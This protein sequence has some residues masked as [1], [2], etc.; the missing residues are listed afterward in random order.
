MEW[1]HEV[2]VHPGTVRMERTISPHFTWRNMWHNIEEYVATCNVCQKFKKHRLRYGELPPSEPETTPWNTVAV[3]LVGPYTVRVHDAGSKSDSPRKTQLLCLTM[4][5]LATRWFEIARVHTKDAEEIALTFD[6][7][8]FSR[9]PRPTRCLHDNGRKFL[10]SEFQELLQ[11]YGV[12]SVATS[13]KNPQTNAVLERTHQVMGNMLRT[14]ELRR[15]TPDQLSDPYLMDGVLSNVAFAI[16]S[17][18][19]TSLNTTP[20]SL[21][22][23]R[24]MLFPTSTWQIGRRYVCDARNKSTRLRIVRIRNESHTILR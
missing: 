5:G 13:V 22:Y 20:A 17:T 11:S 3:D 10:G 16:R 6:R 8:W 14:F 18:F 2:L 4:I 19:H 23:G 24:D 21:V 15:R 1:Y 9:Y 7:T 12:K